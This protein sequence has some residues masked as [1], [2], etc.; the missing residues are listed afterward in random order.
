VQRGYDDYYQPELPF[1]WIN[2]VSTILFTALL[3]T[4]PFFVTVFYICKFKQWHHDEFENK[5]GAVLEGLDKHKISSLFYPV[6]FIIRRIVF[7]VQSIWFSDYF[8]L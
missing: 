6:F 3:V 8:F 1:W 5:M 2:A 4:L 7:A